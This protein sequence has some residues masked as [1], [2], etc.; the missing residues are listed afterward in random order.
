M[1]SAVVLIVAGVWLLLQT[2]AG[3]LPARILALAGVR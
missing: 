3:S 1:A 2:L